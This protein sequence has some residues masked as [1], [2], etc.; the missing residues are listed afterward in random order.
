MKKSNSHTARFSAVVSE[1]RIRNCATSLSNDVSLLPG[2]DDV[3]SNEDI[4]H[5]PRTPIQGLFLKNSHGLGQILLHVVKEAF[6]KKHRVIVSFG[7]GA[8]GISINNRLNQFFVVP[9][10]L[11]SLG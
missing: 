8:V 5:M 2:V 6:A 4:Q 7:F 9:S 1:C 3:I 10:E 11:S